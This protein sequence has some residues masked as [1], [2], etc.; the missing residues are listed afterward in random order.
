MIIINKNNPHMYKLY[1]HLY[2]HV[3]AI[4]MNKLKRTCVSVYIL[5]LIINITRKC[6]FIYIH[7]SHLNAHIQIRMQKACNCNSAC[8]FVCGVYK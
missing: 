6:V 8:A 7:D 1:T 2:I 3:H 5:K 4:Y